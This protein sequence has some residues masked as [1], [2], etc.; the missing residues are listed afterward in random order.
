MLSIV[1]TSLAAWIACWIALLFHELGHAAA[2]EAVGV[3]IW[4]L[5]LG[6]GP[7]IWRGTIEGRRLQIGAFPFL[8]GVTLLDEDA[9]SIGY[10][11][12]MSGRWRFE[13]G[14]DAWRAPI[15]SVA[16]GLSNIVGMLIFL[17][18]LQFAGGGAGDFVHNVLYFGLITNLAGYLNLLPCSRSDGHHL[19]AQLHAARVSVRPSSGR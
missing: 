6:I 17:T 7:T 3:R 4:G 10:R 13:W 16:G 19:I 12:I 18:A 14:P 2:A 15:I 5:Q 1:M 8:G 9:D 11:D